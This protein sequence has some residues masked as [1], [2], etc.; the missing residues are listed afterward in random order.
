MAAAPL[1]A[2][3]RSVSAVA[4]EE[5]VDRCIAFIAQELS[6]SLE[7]IVSLDQVLLCDEDKCI[8]NNDLLIWISY[9]GHTL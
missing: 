5:G 3:L 8:Q 1:A 9:K 4:K 7:N 2:V 6:N